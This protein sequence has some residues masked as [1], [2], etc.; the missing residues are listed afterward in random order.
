VK[1]LAVVASVGART[2]I[3][4]TSAQT[5][6]LYRAGVA[7][8][9]EAPIVDLNEEPV[10]MSLQPTLEPL[11]VGAGRSLRLAIP[12]MEEAMANREVGVASN[13][14]AKRIVCVD[15]GLS[16]KR[17]DGVIPASVVVS[18]LHK[19]AKELGPVGTVEV[20]ARGAAGPG[21]VLGDVVDLLAKGSVDAIVLGGV[22]SDYDP[23][24]ITRLAETGRLYSPD[25]LD[26]IIPG[27]AAAFV[28]L[29]RPDVA[30][31]HQCRVFA[32]VHA[33]ATAFDWPARSRG[34]ATRRRRRIGAAEPPPSASRRSNATPSVSM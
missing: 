4:L 19:R 17:D 3:G 11:L 29:M 7:G 27:E 1:S 15:E 6:F 20:C 16:K 23:A 26:A 8:M 28:V 24:I 13:L 32:Q 30:R 22:G 9:T 34:V 5:A 31:R 33:V 12:A 10:T 21:F 25:N 18:M 14:K 2:A